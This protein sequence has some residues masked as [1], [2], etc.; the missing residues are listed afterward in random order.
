MRGGDKCIEKLQHL[1]PNKWQLII[2]SFHL[3]IY[4][5]DSYERTQRK[6]KEAL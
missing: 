3:Y 2:G 1:I 4:P 5:F 6:T